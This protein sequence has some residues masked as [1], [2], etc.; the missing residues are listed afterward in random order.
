MGHTRPYRMIHR[1]VCTLV[2]LLM[3]SAG[4]MLPSLYAGEGAPPTMFPLELG[5]QWVY[6]TEDGR[7]S[8]SIQVSTPVYVGGKSYFMVNGYSYGQKY[9]NQIFLRQA[10][11]GSLHFY[12]EESEQ[13]LPLTLFEHIPGAWFASR[14]SHCDEEGQVLEDKE[15][16]RFGSTNIASA[17][18]IRY[19]NFSC[20]DL[21]LEKEVYVENLGLVQRT[22]N[23]FQGSLEFRLVYARVGNLIYRNGASAALSLDLDRSHATREAGATTGSPVRIKLRYTVGPNYS[24]SLRFRSGQPYDVFLV[25]ASGNE[26]WRWSDTEAYI[27]PIQEVGFSGYLEYDA[28]LP[29]HRFPEG[30]YTLQGWLNLDSERQ[31]VV[32]IPFKI[33]TIQPAGEAEAT[34]ASR[35]RGAGTRR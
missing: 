6:E 3:C 12:E 4:A 13:D 17:T 34:A 1:I 2:L 15:P 8:F 20:N 9:R 24:G 11:D 28:Y 18:V 25:D 7:Y 21:G 35:S 29:A 16:W 23:T 10:E 27:Q 32:S 22:M 14:L 31:P 19:R 30:E 5:N 26:V 33:S